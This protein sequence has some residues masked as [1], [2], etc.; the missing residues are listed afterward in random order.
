MKK[1]K[2]N[3]PNMIT[4]SRMIASILASVI[5][6]VGNIKLAIGLYVYGA[7]SDFFDGL[8]ARK[9]N[10]TTELGKKLDPISDKIFALS[11][12]TPSIALGNY[13]MFLPFILEGEIASEII[14]AKKMN[15]DMETERIG[16]YKTWFLFTSLI[17]GLLSTKFPVAYFPLAVS[18][19]YTTHF[20]VQSIKAYKNQFNRRII[21]NNEIKK[22]EPKKE[23]KEVSKQNR[24][25]SIVREHYDEFIFYKNIEIKDNQKRLVR[26][27]NN[28]IDF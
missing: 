23:N 26:R 22:E 7:I 27:K 10:A 11:L 17:L 12:L 15:I 5:F 21:N 4:I 13:L 3:I 8:A 9:L 1:I 16:K 2:N 6:V 24:I 25:K 19:G 28:N 18:L 20:Q 14:A